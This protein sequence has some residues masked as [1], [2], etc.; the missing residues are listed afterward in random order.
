MEEI[1]S[2]RI[3]DIE[4]IFKRYSLVAVLAGLIFLASVAGKAYYSAGASVV[5]VL[6]SAFMCYWA[7]TEIHALKA[8]AKALKDDQ[9]KRVGALYGKEEDR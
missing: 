8:I 9:K 2:P 4:S 1:S 7:E 3:R 5:V 6:F